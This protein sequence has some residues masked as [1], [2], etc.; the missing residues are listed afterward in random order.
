MARAGAALTVYPRSLPWPYGALPSDG[1]VISLATLV[2]IST[3]LMLNIK[4]IRQT[5]YRACRVDVLCSLSPTRIP[6]VRQT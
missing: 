3:G 5:S 2:I 4:H 1:L 6:P